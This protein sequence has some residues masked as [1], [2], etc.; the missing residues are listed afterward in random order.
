[1]AGR[2][3][4]GFTHDPPSLSERLRT[5]A[6][7]FGD[8]QHCI[9][10]EAAD[11]IEFMAREIRRLDERTEAQQREIRDL[12]AGLR[13]ARDILS[14]A[15]EVMEEGGTTDAVRLEKVRADTLIAK[16]GGEA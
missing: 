9:T 2:E 3:S 8:G 11:R 16:I 10:H 4:G 6:D 14:M 15:A 12:L 7:V 1:M 5:Y 13:S